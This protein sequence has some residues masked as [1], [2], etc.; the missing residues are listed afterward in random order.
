MHVIY[1][2]MQC[3]DAQQTDMLELERIPAEVYKL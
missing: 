1:A 3:L 2:C